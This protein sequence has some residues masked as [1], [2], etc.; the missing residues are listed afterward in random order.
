MQVAAEPAITFDAVLERLRADSVRHFATPRVTMARRRLLVRPFSQVLEVDIDAEGRTVTAFVKIL[1]P[2]MEGAA[3][4]EATRR[5][6][7]RE[8]ETTARVHGSFAPDAGLSTARPI[9]CYP[10]LLAMV[11][12][13][14]DGVSLNRLLASAR[15][16]PSVSAVQRLSLT[17][18]RVGAW[19]KAF[20]ALDGADG[21]HHDVS[22]EEM[23]TYLDKRL[24]L[25][26]EGG[27]LTAHVRVRLLR[28]FDDVAGKVPPSDLREVPIHADFTPENVIVRDNAVA[29]LDFTMAKRGPRYMDL[30]HMFMHVNLLKAKPWFR[31]AVVDALTTALMGGYDPR[32]RTDHPLF[33]LLLLQHV[34]CHLRQMQ[35]DPPGLA[36]R[37]YGDFLRRRDLKWLAQRAAG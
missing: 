17:M 30:S 32:L 1:K 13:R 4:L 33:E 6:I 11:T 25:L 15:G 8:F 22:L 28:H 31:P 18:G 3:E 9:A 21:G 5:N 20:Q 34:I 24:K 16:F 14:V 35:E 26:A 23:R 7:A 29:V 19:L 12:E 36:A 27:V 2:R 10:D 37:V